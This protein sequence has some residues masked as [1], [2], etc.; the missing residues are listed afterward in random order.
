[1]DADLS[2]FLADFSRLAEA[3]SRSVADVAGERLQD[4]LQAHLGADPAGLPVV[5]EM[6]PAHRL[7]DAA[8]MVEEAAAADPAAR[9]AGIG[10]QER[11][12][13]ALADMVQAGNAYGTP[14]AEP[15]YATVD[16]G[17]DT[18]RRIAVSALHLFRHDG[19]PLAVLFRGQSPVRTNRGHGGG[20]VGGAGG[21]GRV[22]RLAPRRAAGAQ[23][24][25]GAR[26]VLHGQG[27]RPTAAGVTFH[28]RPQVAASDVV[29]PDGALERIVR[30]VVGMGE[31]RENLRTHGQHL[32]RGVLLYGPPGT[33]KT[34]TVRYLLGR[35]R[36][37][38]RSCSPAA[39]SP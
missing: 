9:L 26:G 37:R 3:A 10:G 6:V 12:H 7:T 22:P 18:R 38:R 8:L 17:P 34:H 1:M 29:L 16:T 33:G 4:T 2:R 14:I 31:Q 27:V 23:H 36:A 24:L 13:A 39:P 19:E 21:R 32:K 28:R 25:Q 30:H 15:G 11:H 5:T 20:A 35:A